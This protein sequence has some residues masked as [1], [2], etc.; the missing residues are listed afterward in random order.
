MNGQKL[1]WKKKKKQ[2]T[3]SVACTC[4]YLFLVKSDKI[5]YGSHE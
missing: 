1:L 2:Q 5:E 3:T 4:L